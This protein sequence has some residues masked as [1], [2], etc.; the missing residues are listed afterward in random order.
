[1]TPF[2]LLPILHPEKDIW[3]FG[4]LHLLGTL[5]DLSTLTYGFATF[6]GF[7]KYFRAPQVCFLIIMSP[8]F[9]FP[10]FFLS[11]KST[12]AYKWPY[13]FPKATPMT[14][15]RKIHIIKNASSFQNP[16]KYQKSLHRNWSYGRPKTLHPI[17]LP[18]HDKKWKFFA[19]VVNWLVWKWNQIASIELLN[20]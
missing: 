17:D 18:R 6:E 15:S 4:N 7:L 1:M 16:P 20:P 12:Y 11:P 8:K 10:A 2:Y 5:K 13:I 14:K 9:R 3:N 19:I